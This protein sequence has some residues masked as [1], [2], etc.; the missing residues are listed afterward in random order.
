LKVAALL[1]SDA[2]GERAA[3]Q[4]MLVHTL[5][6]KG[7]LRTKD[8]YEGAVKNPEAEDLLRST[9]VQVAKND[10]GWD[11]VVT[12]AAQPSRPIVDIFEEKIDKFSKY[13]LAKA[14]LRWTRDHGANDLSDDER[15]QWK[16]LIESI[17]AALK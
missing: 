6:N 5:G 15:R 7:I 12:A 8:A 3:Q 4:E 10:L 11:V 14:Y 17:N 1:D 2:A 16:K 13:R 9:L